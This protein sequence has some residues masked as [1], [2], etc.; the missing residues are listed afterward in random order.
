[1]YIKIKLNNEF[2]LKFRSYNYPKEFSNFSACFLLYSE[3][4]VSLIGILFKSI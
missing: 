4:F 2:L 3:K 1:M